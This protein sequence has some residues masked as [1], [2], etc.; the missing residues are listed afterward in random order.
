M[1]PEQTGLRKAERVAES[2]APLSVAAK[3][4]N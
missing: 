2:V 1:S 3:A 4:V